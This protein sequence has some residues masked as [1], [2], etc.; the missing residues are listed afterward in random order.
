VHIGNVGDK[1]DIGDGQFMF[2]TTAVRSN[3]E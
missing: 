3:R 2:Q 1:L